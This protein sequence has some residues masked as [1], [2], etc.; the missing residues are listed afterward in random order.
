[1]SID[2]TP[3][4]FR[5][6][7]AAIQEEPFARYVDLR[8][9]APVLET[10]LA[11]KP[12]WVLSRQEDIATA[13]LNTTSFSSRTVPDGTLLHSDP[14]DH[15]AL[16]SMVSGLFTRAA[17]SSI[18]PFVARRSTELLDKL[19]A[20]EACDI[21]DDFAG[22]LTV[23]VSSRRFGI[24]VDD[25]EQLRAWTKISAEYQRALRLGTRAPEG[26]EEAFRQLF[27]FAVELVASY[28]S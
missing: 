18:E 24:A 27:D 4:L 11:G 19:V 14:P 10:D 1:M 15:R 2:S 17:V 23:S 25:V 8:E 28:T 22:P 7:D 9:R 13:L 3:E 26:A 20:N 16:R 6:D 21:V 12:A 5:L